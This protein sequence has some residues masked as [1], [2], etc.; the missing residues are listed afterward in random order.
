MPD[1]RTG[2]QAADATIN[3][4]I[5]AEPKTLAMRECADHH[6]LFVSRLLTNGLLSCS[7]SCCIAA[8]EFYLV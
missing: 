5:N 4:V 2:A 6:A 1:R 8:G 3:A 7:H